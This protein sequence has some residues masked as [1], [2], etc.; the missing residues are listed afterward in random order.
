MYFCHT[1]TSDHCQLMVIIY[2]F[3]RLLWY[4]GEGVTIVPYCLDPFL[5]SESLYVTVPFVLWIWRERDLMPIYQDQN[6]A[7]TLLL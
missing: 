3:L 5:P 4:M 1:G 7:F 2:S 6:K